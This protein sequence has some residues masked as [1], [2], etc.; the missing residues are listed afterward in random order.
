M[1]NVIMG[2]L[3]SPSDEYLSTGEIKNEGLARLIS[4]GILP[5]PEW[6]FLLDVLK[7][8]I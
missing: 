2:K 3:F 4:A 1:K 7:A 8:E 5:S 6:L